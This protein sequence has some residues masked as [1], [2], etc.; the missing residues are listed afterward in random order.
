MNFV[1]E[2]QRFEKKYLKMDNQ[3]QRN[4]YVI[5]LL[6]VIGTLSC[7][8]S[9]RADFIPSMPLAGA[10]VARQPPA[11]AIQ[12]QNQGCKWST[13]S[14]NNSQK[15]GTSIF[16]PFLRDR[17]NSF[18]LD[19]NVRTLNADFNYTFNRDQVESTTRLNV[20]CNDKLFF[21]SVLDS[22]QSY[23]RLRNLNDV[24]LQSC[25]IRKIPTR[26]WASLGS[27]K[28]LTISSMNNE[29]SSA[30]GMEIMNGAFEGL[31][32]TLVTLDISQNNVFSLPANVLCPLRSLRTFNVS[33]N[34]LV[35]TIS[36]GSTFPVGN[37]E[38]GS[39][40][41]NIQNLDLS[42]NTI[43]RINSN[44]FNRMPKLTSLKLDNNYIQ[45]LSDNSFNGLHQLNSIHL[46]N[47]K[48]VALPPAIFKFAPNLQNKLREINLRNNSISA[49][50]PLVFSD[51]TMLLSLDLSENTLTSQ[52]ITGN[53][54]HGLTRLI[55]LKLS[56]NKLSYIDATIFKDLVNLQVNHF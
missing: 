33:R 56:Y 15:N 3:Q 4:S 41:M 12:Q 36:F 52:W 34:R 39:C 40:V 1:D 7:A 50:S 17:S 22:T 35:E 25:K 53:M 23:F 5:V 26:I 14:N 51:L 20:K 18:A 10:V 44:D 38:E 45:E 6:L 13:E 47:N 8:D 37:S 11:H 31:E 32:N 2:K 42:Y 24:S 28:R 49:L 43:R 48:L 27:L 19:C 29:W 46:Q 21:E 9:Y 55:V 54:F 30:F 16:P